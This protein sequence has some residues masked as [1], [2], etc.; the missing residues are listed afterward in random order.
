MIRKPLARSLAGLLLASCVL[1]P[2]LA[3]NITLKASHQFPG[4]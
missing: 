4:G 2:A 3:E 1:A